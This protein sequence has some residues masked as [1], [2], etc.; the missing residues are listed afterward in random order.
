MLTYAS[1][2]LPTEVRATDEDDT[3]GGLKKKKVKLMWTPKVVDTTTT[4]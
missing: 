3:E 2:E 1:S 4:N